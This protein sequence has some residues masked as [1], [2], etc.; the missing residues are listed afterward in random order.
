MYSTSPMHP[1]GYENTPQLQ[2]GA[3]YEVPKLQH[4]SGSYMR[5]QVANRNVHTERLMITM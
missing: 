2:I 3:N 5:Y 1:R 4:C